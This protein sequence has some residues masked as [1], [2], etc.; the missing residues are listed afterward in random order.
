MLANVTI[1][2]TLTAICISSSV[3]NVDLRD[4]L[5][6]GHPVNSLELILAVT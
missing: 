3:I 2:S 6:L 1:C 4:M 5:L